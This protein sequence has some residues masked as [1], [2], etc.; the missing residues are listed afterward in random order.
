MVESP[1]QIG[2]LVLKATI[3]QT[4][5]LRDLNLSYWLRRGKDENQE[6]HDFP[7]GR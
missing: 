3:S 2:V 1:D 4:K 7:S 6:I 5:P